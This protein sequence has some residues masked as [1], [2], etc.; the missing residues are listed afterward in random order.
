[1]HIACVW[2]GMSKKKRFRVTHRGRRL[3]VP[4]P[5]PPPHFHSMGYPHPPSSSS[6][7]LPGPISACA[8]FKPID[9]MYKDCLVLGNNLP[10]NRNCQMPVSQG[11]WG[12]KYVAVVYVC[13][14][15]PTVLPPWFSFFFFFFFL[16]LKKREE[17]PAM[18]CTY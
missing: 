8:L 9:C 1:M 3:L 13:T 10:T 2:D 18:L 15:I 12:W 14:Y 17:N 16:Q 5:S 4:P 11:S 6:P 7:R